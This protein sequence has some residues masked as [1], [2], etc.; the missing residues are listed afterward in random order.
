MSQERKERNMDAAFKHIAFNSAKRFVAG[1]SQRNGRPVVTQEK[2]QRILIQALLIEVL[3]E[4][5]DV[6]IKIG[7]HGGVHLPGIVAVP[8]VFAPAV[9]ISP[10]P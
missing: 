3:H 8:Q 4:A 9:L 5:A 2:D 6:V 7:H 1:V 10:M